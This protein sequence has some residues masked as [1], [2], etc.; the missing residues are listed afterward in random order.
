MTAPPTDTSAT[1]SLPGA[2]THLSRLPQF[3]SAAVAA[4]DNMATNASACSRPG[5]SY[6]SL[7]SLCCPP[8][9]IP[10]PLPVFVPSKAFIVEADH[11]PFKCPHQGCNKA[12]RK[13]NLLTYHIKYYH[14][15]SEPA[16]SLACDTMG[17][18]TSPL[19]QSPVGTPGIRKRRKKTSSICSTDSDVS[20]SSKGKS[21]CKRYRDSEFSSLAAATSPDILGRD[22][23]TDGKQ[24]HMS[25]HSATEEFVAVDTEDEDMEADVVNCVCG[26]RETSGLMIQ[27]SI[28]DSCRYMFDMGWERRGEL[29][30]FPFVSDS[31]MEHLKSIACEC[32]EMISAIQAIKAA[33]HSTRRQIKISKEDADPEF[34]LW[35]TDWDN[36]TK[37]EEDLTL[38]PRSGDPDPSPTPSTFLF[39]A[40]P[41]PD[42]TSA[43]TEVCSP[44]IMVSS[45][46]PLLQSM[47]HVTATLA[48]AASILDLPP[49]MSQPSTTEA[50]TSAV[51]P[52]A[53]GS[54]TDILSLAG[55]NPAPLIT[56][57]S[58]SSCAGH[59]HTMTSFQA[60]AGGLVRDLFSGCHGDNPQSSSAD[61]IQDMDCR[62]ES[63]EEK[64]TEQPSPVDEKTKSDGGSNNTVLLQLG[65][66]RFPEPSSSG[67]QLASAGTS[68]SNP[69]VCNGVCLD[70]KTNGRDFSLE[71]VSSCALMS[72][73]RDAAERHGSL[74]LLVGGD[75]QDQLSSSSLSARL[76]RT[77]EMNDSTH[78]TSLY[79]DPQVDG[80]DD[81]DVP[82]NDTDTAE[83]SLDPYRNCEQN[84]LIH[85]SRVHSD[86]EKQLELLEQQITDLETSEHS[87]PTVHLTEDNVLNDVPA[88]KKSLSKL[89][90]NLASLEKLC[91]HH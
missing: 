37:P 47:L 61:R 76:D 31:S 66:E 3:E 73:G 50:S 17:S 64:E 26:L 55:S 87:N 90:R 25:H 62:T 54:H 38:T 48:E 80:D 49:V 29:P 57:S 67:L 81:D 91:V 84:L 60:Q 89:C 43:T 72:P 20:V 71:T 75:S 7:L 23:W 46:D 59:S 42:I 83:E 41:H 74:S 40:A 78:V 22:L 30:S 58:S 79:L 10:L 21:S 53:V 45:S 52:P 18:V 34:Q 70:V 56:P 33:L 68:S 12:F 1:K 88:L 14:T 86:I 13:E 4:T 28:R 11:N 32:N 65:S 35:Q 5:I 51:T 2:V 39:S 19:L 36:W 16:G 69:A 6:L 9:D 44:S 27:V 8:A 63:S 82:D 85:V 24:P 15:Q 77:V